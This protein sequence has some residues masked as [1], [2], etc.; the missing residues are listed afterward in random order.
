MRDSP[1]RC[2]ECGAK[3]SVRPWHSPPKIPPKCEGCG[4]DLP[5]HDGRDWL[6]WVCVDPVKFTTDGYVV[7]RDNIS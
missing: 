3:Y 4:R 5:E 1:I 2:F 7:V 6:S